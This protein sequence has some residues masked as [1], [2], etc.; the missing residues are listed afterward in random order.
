LLCSYVEVV[1]VFSCENDCFDAQKFVEQVIELAIIDWFIGTLVE[2][3][4]RVMK[5][6]LVW[7]VAIFFL[8]KTLL[9]SFFQVLNG[10]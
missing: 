1:S 4:M 10:V 5:V 8:Q 2:F 6:W 3:V 7:I 9:F